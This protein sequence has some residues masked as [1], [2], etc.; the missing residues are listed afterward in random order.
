MGRSASLAGEVPGEPVGTAPARGAAA[1]CG[2][3]AL[4]AARLMQLSPDEVAQEFHALGAFVHVPEFLPTQLSSRLS[5]IAAALEPHVHRNRLPGHKQ[6]GSVSRH[7][8]DELAPEVARLYRAPA[9]LQWLSR[10]A[11]EPLQLSP[12]EDPHAYALYYYTRPGDFIGWHY[13]TS[14]YAGRRY[15]VLIGVLDESSCELQYEL[16]TREAGRT[17]LPGALRIPPGGLVFFDGDRLRHRIT[18]LRE[19]ER[20]VALTLEYLTDARMHRG[21]R[22]ISNLKDAFGYFG[23][24]DVFRRRRRPD[25]S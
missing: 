10:V 1:D 5:T 6:G 17:P 13:D 16:Y 23:F 4:L 3:E 21:W 25:A 19:G 24:A 9:L 2:A 20:R 12:A 18:P 22:L 11:G 7:G 8:L 15:T 14:Y